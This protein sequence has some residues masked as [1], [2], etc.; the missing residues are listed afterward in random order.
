MMKLLVAADVHSNLEALGVLP[1]GKLIFCGDFIG[2]GANPNQVVESLEKRDMEAVIGNHDKA[3]LTGEVSGMNPFAATAALWTFKQ[4]SKQNRQFL[5]NLPEKKELEIEGKRI[6]VVHGSP[7]DPLNEYLTE[8]GLIKRLL[9]VLPYDIILFGH[10]HIPVMI[11]EG[12]KL[13]LNPGSIGQPR[14][15]DPKASWAELELPNTEARIQKKE[16]DVKTAASKILEADLPPVLAER[17]YGG[18]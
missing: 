13:A 1:K 5:L 10:T 11:R 6:L 17:L 18:W 9:K 12:D 7:R 8:P 3:G 14:D 16:Y 2:Y 4:L 15:G